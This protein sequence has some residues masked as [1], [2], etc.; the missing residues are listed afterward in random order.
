M[1]AWRYNAMPRIYNRYEFNSIRKQLRQNL[2]K[3]EIVLWS[4][5]K[6]R[7]LGHKFRR[8]YGI[9]PYI[10]DF[11]CKELRLVVEVDG[12]E[13][14]EDDW[15]ERDIGRQKY[16]ESHFIQFIRFSNDEVL[17][18]TDGV[19]ERLLDFIKTRTTPFPS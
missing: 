10:V 13:H 16:I 4:R 15:R 2:T 7:Q 11:F 1:V 8:Q 14:L 18:D 12:E 19:I 17:E 5:L 6:G 3:A 9:G